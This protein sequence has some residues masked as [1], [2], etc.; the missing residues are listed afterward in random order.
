MANT[1]ESNK[2][3]KTSI[4]SH[5]LLARRYDGTVLAELR[6]YVTSLCSM[7]MSE[8]TELVLGAQRLSPTHPTLF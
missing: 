8:R 5:V 2:S 4:S 3:V 1:H 7:E 6:Q